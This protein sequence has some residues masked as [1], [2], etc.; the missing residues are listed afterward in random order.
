M[1]EIWPENWKE[2]IEMAATSTT[3]VITANSDGS[4]NA[5]VA[6]TPAWGVFVPNEGRQIKRILLAIESILQT[7]GFNY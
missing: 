4:V 7:N 1:K 3:I 2:C 6:A 5:K